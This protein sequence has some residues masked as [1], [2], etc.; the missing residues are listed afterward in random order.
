MKTETNRCAS[1]GLLRFGRRHHHAFRC[2]LSGIPIS[3]T[4]THWS[5]NRRWC[6]A[7]GARC[8]L[9]HRRQ[10]RHRRIVT[11]GKN[12][13]GAETTRARQRHMLPGP[14]AGSTPQ[15]A[16]SAAAAAAKSGAHSLCRAHSRRRAAACGYSGAAS[17]CHRSIDRSDFLR[18]ASRTR[19]VTQS[20]KSLTQTAQLTNTP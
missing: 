12:R 10:Y 20:Q 6:R 3:T 7:Q 18:R 14:A 1:A 5:C 16:T 19:L 11:L 15:C 2:D 17:A 8:P 9:E 4:H 13:G